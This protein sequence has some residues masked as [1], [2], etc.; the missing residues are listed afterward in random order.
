MHCW[1]GRGDTGLIAGGFL[2]DFIKGELNGSVDAELERGLRLHRHIDVQS[3]HLS[4]LK[5]T[6]HRFG[7]KLRRPAPILLDLMADHVLARHWDR[8]AQ[9]E[10]RDFTQHCYAAIGSFAAPPNATRFFTHMRES[11]LLARY[12]QLDTIED[13]MVR[14]LRRLHYE[15]LESELAKRLRDYEAGFKQ[16]FESYFVDLQV[17][18]QQWREAAGVP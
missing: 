15:H 12:A 2:G 3:N 16:D 4:S 6:Y 13:I 10:L 11:D 1:L 17:V 7:S 9:G 18:A 5:S 14:I 8:F